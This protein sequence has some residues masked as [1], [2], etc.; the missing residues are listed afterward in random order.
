VKP[1][2]IPWIVVEH[3]RS[4]SL[5]HEDGS[6]DG[7]HVGEIEA[8]DKVNLDHVLACV[9]GTDERTQGLVKALKDARQTLRALGTTGGPHERGLC[10]ARIEAALT[11]AGV[12]L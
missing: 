10:I 3:R 6:E 1:T 12:T 8:M 7:V 5:I 2:P 4:I 9:H 11:A